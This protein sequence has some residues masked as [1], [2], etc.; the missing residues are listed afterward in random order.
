MKLRFQADADLKHAI[1]SGV[2]RRI[3][4]VDFQRATDVP[5]EGVADLDVLAIAAK[6]RRVL[7]SHDKNTM[8]AHY[9][10]FTALATSPGLILVPQTG[11]PLARAIEGLVL[12]WELMEPAELENRICLLPSLAILS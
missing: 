8:I 6:E 9:R 11:F 4:V 3:P 5:L 12:I 7:V 2:R 10:E 1:I